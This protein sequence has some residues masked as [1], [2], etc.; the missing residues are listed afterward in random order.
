VLLIRSTVPNG[1][2]RDGALTSRCFSRSSAEPRKVLRTGASETLKGDP[3][4]H[5]EAELEEYKFIEVQGAPPLTGTLKVSVRFASSLTLFRRTGGMFGYVGYDCVQYFEPKTA[6]ELKDP[7]GMPESVFLLADTLVAFDHLFQKVQVVSHVVLPS[8][9]PSS[10]AKDVIAASY[11]EAQSKII[12]IVK[13][14]ISD[15]ALPL[16]HQPKI[17]RPPKDAESNVGKAGYEGFVTS[18]KKN[19]VQ[20]DIIQAVPSQRLRRETALHPFNVYR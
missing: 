13:T 11:A 9:T 4:K 3:L 17:V 19:I 16:P 7:I 14:L 6:R 2:E 5:I 8:N 18:L 10:S 15:S 20:G 12:E 1:S